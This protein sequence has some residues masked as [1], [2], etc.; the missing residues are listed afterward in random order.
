MTTNPPR[1]GVIKR[2]QVR[3]DEHELVA[4]GRASRTVDVGPQARLVQLGEGVQA[5][6][7]TCSCGEVSL[8]EITSEKQ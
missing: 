1:Q 6:E 4:P 5:V 7:F 2:D 8:I 3:V